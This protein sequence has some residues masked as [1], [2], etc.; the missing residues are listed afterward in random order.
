MSLDQLQ[1]SHTY[2]CI[3]LNLLSW[4]LKIFISNSFN[5]IVLMSSSIVSATKIYEKLMATCQ[6][7]HFSPTILICLSN[8]RFY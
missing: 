6:A 8:N 1:T 5:F 7:Q 3:H 4:V 2:A